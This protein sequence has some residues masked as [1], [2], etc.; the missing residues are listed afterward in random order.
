M[1]EDDAG[2]ACRGAINMRIAKL[3]MDPQDKTRF[4]VQGKSSV[5]YHLKANHQVEAKRWFWTLNNAI[6]WS[7]DEAKDQERQKQRKESVL[8][9]AKA[10][11]TVS[12]VSGGSGKADGLGLSSK[13]LTPATLAGGPLTAT[14][15]RVS[16]QD[17][18]FGIGSIA[19]DD[20]G[21][22]YGSREHSIAG[23]DIG[24]EEGTSRTAAIAGDA[25]DDEEYGDDASSHELRPASKDAFN[26]TA[27]SA[28]LQL[29]LLSQVSSALQEETTKEQAMSVSDPTIVQALATYASAVASLQELV[30][31]LL[32]ISR[33]RDAYWQGRLDREADVRR[34]WEDSMA[35]VARE[36]E[37]LEGRIEESEE[38]RKRTKRALRDALEGQDDS[39]EQPTQV[40]SQNEVG[41]DTEVH[42][43]PLRR[44]SSAPR[45]RKSV[46]VKDL[47]RRKST[48]AGF[49]D[50]SDSDSDEDEEFFDAVDAGEVE[51]VDIMPESMPKEASPSLP[52]EREQKAALNV[53][54]V[55][56]SEIE[57]SFHGY[58][59]PLRERL[60]MDSDDRPKISLWVII[61]RLILD[62]YNTN[63]EKKGI[64]KSMIGKDMTK[65]TLP[66]SFNEPTSLLQRVTEDMEYSD[67]LDTAADRPEST[68][69]LVYVAA[70]AASEYAS[71]IGRIAKPF[72]PLLGETYE[73]VRPDK[74]YRFFIEQVSHHPPIGAAWAEAPKWDYYVGLILPPAG[75]LT[76]CL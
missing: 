28:S 68:E 72:N 48:I 26:I 10:G 31:N 13:A 21:S 57:P 35:K 36:Q 64:L 39:N 58:E 70:F 8:R 20:D 40:M 7:K 46:G 37:E 15:S 24:Q 30:N 47:S 14:T 41:I 43:L 60:R 73:Y 69:R 22:L 65:M 32:K 1:Y 63:V 61:M 29:D 74:G 53:R 23:H 62:L 18:T 5:K 42:R 49:T 71:T 55:R 12:D 25:D 11:N 19:G 4:E 2:S 76:Y 33:D 9:E 56:R 75:A 44:Q 66:V 52:K 17:S 51:V 54:D 6:Q 16:L 50:L 38:K 45:R 34:L 27:H 3:H 59:D 67:L